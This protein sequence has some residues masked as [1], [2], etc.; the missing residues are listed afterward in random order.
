[1]TLKILFLVFCMFLFIACKFVLFSVL[2]FS[3]PQIVS[4]KS[5]L[6]FHILES[7]VQNGLSWINGHLY[8]C[9]IIFLF[10]YIINWFYQHVSQRMY[11][12]TDLCKNLY[13]LYFATDHMTY[14]LY[15][16]GLILTLRSDTRTLLIFW[17]ESPVLH[18][19]C[20]VPPTFCFKLSV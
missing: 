13:C 8:Q 12:F 15:L 18:I 19:I 16:G 6:K 11:S 2:K 4:V 17:Q 14:L 7:M 10:L 20:I 3:S 5:N 9:E 1:M